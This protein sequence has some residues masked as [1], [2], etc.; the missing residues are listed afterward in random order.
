MEGCQFFG[1]KGRAE[2]RVVITDDLK[3]KGAGPAVAAAVA[4]LA[5]FPGDQSLRAS[6]P[7]LSLKPEYVAA[8]H[9]EQPRHFAYAQHTG[10]QFL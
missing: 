2:I 1:C 8:R 5:A 7:V 4:R 3:R 6:C 9:P 10:C